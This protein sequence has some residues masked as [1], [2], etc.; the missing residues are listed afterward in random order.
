MHQN[1]STN[2]PRRQRSL[3]RHENSSTIRPHAS[4]TSREISSREMNEY[5]LDSDS[6]TPSGQD[7]LVQQICNAADMA[8]KAK[9]IDRLLS[10]V[11]GVDYSQ[12]QDS[13]EYAGSN[14]DVRKYNEHSL[15]SDNPL[16][17]SKDQQ[18]VFAVN[19]ENESVSSFRINED[20]SL[21]SVSLNVPTD[22]KPGSKKPVSL[23]LYDDVLYVVNAGISEA[24]NK[25]ESESHT[26]APKRH[27]SS[28]ASSSI[29][30]LK[31]G[32]D[33]TLSALT[34]FELADLRC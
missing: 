20:Y 34:S 28:T 2:S 18:F 3:E 22:D 5:V 21:T 31:V 12:V 33:G 16:I 17:F 14:P 27:H 29:T 4:G 10:Y 8:C 6:Y 13:V 24:S 25:N 7:E 32:K 1:I 23:T 19:T 9:R 30:G 15:I 26:P 11:S